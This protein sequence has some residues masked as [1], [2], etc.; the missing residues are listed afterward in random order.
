MHEPL[1]PSYAFGPFVLDASKRL[2]LRD[3]DPVPLAPKVL[4]TL[5]A[6]IEHR[7]EVISKE[8]LLSRVWGDTVVEEG[9]LARNI[10]LLR[11]TLGEKPDEHRY[12]VTVP[13]RG[14]RFVADVREDAAAAPPREE[15]SDRREEP[16]DRESAIARN[17]ESNAL[18]AP[19]LR[20]NEGIDADQKSLGVH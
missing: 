5:L 20:K 6:L 17:G 3:G 19:G 18:A 4:D 9:G 12:I 14:Y 15:S 11:K 2:L 16:S 7:S 8:Q 10:S 1:R 13:A